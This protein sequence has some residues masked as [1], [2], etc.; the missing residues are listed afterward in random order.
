MRSTTPFLSF[1]LALPFT[2]HATTWQVG[3]GLTYTMPSQVSTLVANG[4][5]VDI[6]A[7]TYPSDVA[8]WTADDLLLR[9]VGGFAHLESNGMAWG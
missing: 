8:A 9:G 4:D 5:T 1:L 6:A 3:P 2:A 7:G